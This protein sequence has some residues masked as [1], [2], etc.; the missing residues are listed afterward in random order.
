MKYKINYKD[1]DL[2][3]INNEIATDS[4]QVCDGCKSEYD[5]SYSPIEV[6]QS[7]VYMCNTCW[8]KNE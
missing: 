5:S 6:K 7:G 1:E 8:D 3:K 4:I 2:Y